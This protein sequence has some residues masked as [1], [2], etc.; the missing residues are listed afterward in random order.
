MSLKRFTSPKNLRGLDRCDL[1]TDVTAWRPQAD[2][3]LSVKDFN[4][5]LDTTKEWKVSTLCPEPALTIRRNHERF[6]S[7]G[8]GRFCAFDID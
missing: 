7:N 3:R 1:Q 5:P 4:K 6:V 8:A 2:A